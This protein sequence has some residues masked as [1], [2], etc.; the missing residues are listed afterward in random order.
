MHHSL[1]KALSSIFYWL[2][3]VYPMGKRALILK[4]CAK[5][6]AIQCGYNKGAFVVTIGCIFVYTLYHTMWYL[7]AVMPSTI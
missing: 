6:S 4:G 2:W 1:F 7:R 3:V 5:H